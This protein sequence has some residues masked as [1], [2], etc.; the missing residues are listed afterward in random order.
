MPSKTGPPKG[1]ACAVR[2]LAHAGA[3]E[4]VVASAIERVDGC[5]RK[6]I[7]QER[8]L[9]MIEEGSLLRAAAW[10]E[11]LLTGTMVTVVAIL[12]VASVGVAMMAGRVEW[13][14]GTE[15]VLGVFLI[16]GAS[17]IAQ[18]LVRHPSFRA[19]PPAPITVPPVVVE[20][21][22]AAVY[23]PYAG[24]AVPQGRAPSD[25]LDTGQL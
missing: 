1:I 24:A 17:A 8:G 2:A 10:I 11:S 14:R 3:A 6:R 12:A 16:F 4:Q 13:R 22:P 25:L 21:P 9:S 23:D 20:V 18:G 15:V 7:A 19:Y 5:G